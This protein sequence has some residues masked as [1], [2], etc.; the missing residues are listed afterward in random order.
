MSEKAKKSSAF[1]TNPARLGPHGYR[2]NKPKWEQEMASGQ[3]A[4]P[5]YELKSERS[6]DYVMGRRS[7]NESGSKII[8]ANMEPVVKK[9][10]RLFLVLVILFSYAIVLKFML[11]ALTDRCTN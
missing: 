9:M 11:F 3:L 10:V 4:P 5:L 1:N 8:P 7:K 6:R 2:G